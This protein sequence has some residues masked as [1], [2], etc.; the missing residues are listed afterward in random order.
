MGEVSASS[1]GRPVVRVPAVRRRHVHTLALVLV[2]TLVLAGCGDFSDPPASFTVQPSL[3]PIAP[4]PQDPTT[5]TPPVPTPSPSS[6][7]GSSGASSEPAPS[8]GAVEDPCAPTDEAVVATCLAAPWGLA[9]LPDGSALVGE[10]TTGRILQVARGQEPAEY[11]TV[12][13]LDA[14][15]TGG[16]LGLVLSPA[17]AEDHLIYAY[18]TTA[19]DNRIL[20]IASGEEPRAVFTGIPKGSVHNGG[21]I[22]FAGDGTLLVGTGDTGNPA[23]AGD[24]AS[25]AGKVLRLDEFGRPA[26]DNPVAGSPILARGFTDVVGACVL[27]DRSVAVLDRREDADVL[28]EPGPDRDYSTLVS[29]DTLWTFPRTEGGADDCAVDNGTLA[30]TSRDAKSLTGLPI[31]DTNG[32]SGAPTQLL[33]DRYGRLLTVVPDG[34]GLLWMTTSNKDGVGNPVPSDDRVIVLPSSPDGGG[35]GPD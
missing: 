26:P 29:G 13:D 31:S 30:T 5:A 33:G 35:G 12:A 19:T 15:G 24:P 1:P 23:L 18:V 6:T 21:R 8:S 28:I 9:P 7:P 34:Q 4:A 27:A 22:A 25:L 17:F 11:A 3:S 20:R 32:F 16:L 14:S 10:R 2:G